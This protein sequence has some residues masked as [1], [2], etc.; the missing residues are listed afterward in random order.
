VRQVRAF[1]HRA[2]RLARKWSNGVLP[3]PVSDTD[4]PEW[5]LHERGP[6]VR[7]PSVE[8]VR[9]LVTAAGDEGLR[10]GVF[11][12]VAAASGAR[13]GEVCALR[14]GGVDLETGAI[15]IS[16]SIVLDHGGV[17]VR[18]P[19]TRAS[20]RRVALDPDTVGALAALRDQAVRDAAVAGVDVPADAFVFGT[21]PGGFAAPHPDAMSHAFGRIRE[22]AGVSA[23]VHLHSLRHFQSTVLDSVISE[24]QKQARMGWATVQMARHYTDAVSDEDRRAAAY[25]GDVLKPGRSVV[26]KRP[27][28]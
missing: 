14:W 16:E 26:T 1:L 23:D 13:R 3:N 18:Q 4:I 6:A 8:E 19:K 15:R 21:E 5:Q 2:C 11:V 20:S 28:R 24:A 17:V 9:A 22:R 10:L 7:A 25:V 27:A 12:R